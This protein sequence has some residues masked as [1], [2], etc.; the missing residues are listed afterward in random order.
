LLDDLRGIGRLEEAEQM[1][2]I[3]SIGKDILTQI[4]ARLS[5]LGAGD[6][7]VPSEAFAE[8]RADVQ[9][10]LDSFFE[11]DFGQHNLASQ[12]PYMDDVEKILKAAGRLKNSHKRV[13]FTTDNYLIIL[14][15]IHRQDGKP[16]WATNRGAWDG[17][18]SSQLSM[19][20]SENCHPTLTKIGSKCK[21]ILKV[22]RVNFNLNEIDDSPVN[23]PESMQFKTK[24]PTFLGFAEVSSILAHQPH[25]TM[26]ERMADWNLLGVDQV[27]VLT[28]Y[29]TMQC[30]RSVSR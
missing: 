19:P 15:R 21:S 5:L 11:I 10:C 23:V 13:G 3:L 16:F 26:A 12:Q 25:A 30:W 28:D 17:V 18:H 7:I 2:K 1:E 20:R 6:T 24:E 22:K 29:S 8:I 27:K 4:N 14:L 9:A